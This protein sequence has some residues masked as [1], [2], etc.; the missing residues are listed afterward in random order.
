METIDDSLIK[1]D[2]IRFDQIQNV[3]YEDFM[4]ARQRTPPFKVGD[5]VRLKKGNAPLIVES[6][7]FLEFSGEYR[8][9]A[10]YEHQG[11]QGSRQSE[12]RASDFVPFHHNSNTT[13]PIQE[14][15]M[16]QK[17]YETADG[18]YG[19]FM[20]KNRQ[21]EFVL[22]MKGGESQYEAFDPE[23]LTEVRPYTVQLTSAHSVNVFEAEEGLL[24]VGDILLFGPNVCVV[25]AIDTKTS[26]TSGPLPP[27]ARRLV[28]EP[29]KPAAKK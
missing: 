17:L 20:I 5:R 6:V 23:T 10:Y 13:K 29:I 8:V 27:E 7:R 1:F 2:R 15:N 21:G 28:T 24:E 22:E 9:T 16:D 11:P 12:R 25:T 14:E 26:H 3:H 19:R 18:R 4:K